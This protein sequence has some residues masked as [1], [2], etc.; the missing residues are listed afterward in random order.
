M[1]PFNVNTGRLDPYKNFKFRVLWDGRV[2]SGVS[3]VSALKRTTEPVIHR[4]GGGPSN[5]NLSPGV[6]RFEP[7]IM[8]RGVTH[9]TAFE[10]W[11]NLVF[12]VQGDGEV[13]LANFRKDILI[14][15]VNLSGQV[16]IAYQ[17]FR[18][19]VSEYQPLSE[20]DA[21]GDGATAFERIVIQNE[22]W[23]RDEAVAE[24]VEP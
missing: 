3:K 15:L 8:E 7:I 16:V 11:A 9:D 5:Q 21:T 19:W 14:Q 6:T 2:V 22:G 1:P 20:L 23:Q 17:V 4:E 18:C 13:S 10:D 24:P 12:S